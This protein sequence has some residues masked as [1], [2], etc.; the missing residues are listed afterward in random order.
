MCTHALDPL[1]HALCIHAAVHDLLTGQHRGKRATS[2][3]LQARMRLTE[4]TIGAPQPAMISAHRPPSMQG[5]DPEPALAWLTSINISHCDRVTDSGVA[6][7]AGLTTLEELDMSCCTYVNRAGFAAIATLPHLSS[8]TV[9]KVMLSVGSLESIG[10][11][12]GKRL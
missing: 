4:E 6:A 3:V 11:M 9:A 8:L 1:G 2:T 5:T 10:C 12:T 7:L